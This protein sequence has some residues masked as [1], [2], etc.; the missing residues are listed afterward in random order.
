MKLKLSKVTSKA[1]LIILL[2]AGTANI[3]NAQR[4]KKVV[5]QAFWWD[6]WN[7]NFKFKWADYLTE[8]APRLK[9]LGVDAVWIPPNYKNDGPGSVGYSPFD[10]YDLG[11]KFQK[12]ETASDTVRT[13]SGNKDELL[14][15]IAVMHA[16]GIEVIQDV[17][18]N[19]SSGAGN[20]GGGGGRD[21]T[22]T[23]SQYQDNA[24]NY[25]KNFRY[26]CYNTP[27]LDTSA[28]DYWT[29]KGRW[30]KNLP[31][32]YPNAS[33]NAVNTN[34]INTAYFGP[35]MAYENN[36]FGFSSI[37]PKTG[38]ATISGV[39]KSYF[40]PTQP[41]NYM[42][43]SAKDWI[44]W[45][46]KQTGA[47]GFRWDAVK[48]FGFDVQRDLTYALKYQSAFAN[49]GNNM[50]NVGEWVGQASEIDYYAQQLI[51]SGTPSESGVSNEQLSGGFDFGLRGYSASGGLY[52]MVLNGGS[53]DMQSIPGSQQSQA[54]RYFDYPNGTRVHKTV[55]FVNSHDTYRPALTSTGNYSKAL[56]DGTGWGPGELGGNGQHIDPREPR[57]AAANAV[58]AAVDG[59][60]CF[61]IEDVFDYFSL[62]KRWTHLPANADSLP[63]R[64]DVGNIMQCHQ[65][66][67]FKDGNYGVPTAISGAG[68]S[69]FYLTGS[70]G[71]HL[72]IE[73]IGKALIGITDAYS[74]VNNNSQDQQVYVSC[75]AAWDTGT[76]L[77]DYSGAHGIVGTKIFADRRVLIKTA[78][79]G[80]NI[81][82]VF[83]HGYSIWAPYPSGTP[84]SIYD[85]FSYIISYEQPRVRT[86]Q[87][88]WEMA[89][90]LGDSHC[91]SLGQG[92]QLPANSANQRVAGKIFVQNGSSVTYKLLP[93]IDNTNISISL[94]D[95]DGN[96][97]SEA[98]G[99][100]TAALPISGAYNCTFTGWITVK[101]R[102]ANISQPAQKCWANV[103]YTAPTSINTRDIN[104]AATT[105]VSIWT[106]NKGTNNI[107]D[108]GNWEE[109]LIPN[110]N[111]NIIVPNFA[112]PEPLFYNSLAGRVI[113][114]ANSGFFK[115]VNKVDLKISLDT[116]LQT[117]TLPNGNYEFKNLAYGSYK[118]K[119]FKNNDSIKSNGVSSIDVILIQN[120]ILNKIKLN[121]AYK[122]IAAD[123]NNDK[124]ISSIDIIFIKRL[125]LGIDTTF[126]GSRTW[127][128]VDS[129]FTFIDSTKPFPYKDSI[130]VTDLTRS[131]NNQ[132]FIG[133]KLGDVSYDWKP[134]LARG[135]VN[136]N[137]ELILENDRKKIINNDVRIPVS[138]KN[139]KQI[140]ALQY[141]LNFNNKDYE[142][143]GL[144]NNKLNIDFNDAQ[145]K[146]NGSISFLWAD[147]NALEKTLIDGTD[148]FT[149]VFRSKKAQ[150]NSISAIDNLLLKLDNS[151]TNI[152]AWDK[153]YTQRNVVMGRKI[154]TDNQNIIE[155]WSVNPNPTDGKISIFINA[156]TS[157]NVVFV[158]TNSIGKKVLELNY[159]VTKG[160]NTFNVNLKNNMPLARGYYFL[161]AK[162]IDGE[163]T[164]K[165]MIQ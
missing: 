154:L 17:V 140:L 23:T 103:I 4:V 55:P 84:T 120:H 155:S 112:N 141:T 26:T 160:A 144:D 8:L 30:S 105:R 69:P 91:A 68:I 12:G 98:I 86:T 110:A 75:N 49:G 156:K 35:D 107:T 50:L 145:Q 51:K 92:G 119:P 149:L 36:S 10:H 82:S 126:R 133:I 153:N 14:R 41:N 63:L 94:W 121:S 99:N 54:Y 109:G 25:F 1:I 131:K 46:K 39:T 151:I 61:Y 115:N 130:I 13:R 148:I 116:L 53:Y 28:A 161:K 164:K 152:E 76:I 137:I 60:P 67:N 73:R 123:V 56:G 22:A 48:H 85:L 62:D 40:N 20:R 72:V 64:K 117:Q 71:D 45:Y 57:F 88:E 104:N 34:A 97:L 65:K 59:N 33:N 87:Q 163:N 3:V 11:D 44:V 90:D 31:N 47:D 101:V 58:I 139:F 18:L 79:C 9:A 143:V 7:S 78:P 162:E 93:G 114:P 43:Q 70:S 159:D 142:F 102:N 81:P 158:L 118:I 108:C 16:N 132:T 38:N 146:L 24:S 96:M 111:S 106:G 32:F 15:M 52:N 21:L 37:I 135:I 134:A 80:H 95:L 5:F 125:I 147:K 113:A 77:Y 165:I 89:D 124:A 136:N 27:H 19:H 100:S 122:I 157:R 128:F 127:A 83:G 6:N 66:L 42:A 29:R 138:V 150:A 2:F 129:S 74:P